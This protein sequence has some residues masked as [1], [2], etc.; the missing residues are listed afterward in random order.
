MGNRQS[1]ASS[2]KLVN[3]VRDANVIE[4]AH[5]DALSILNEDPLLEQ[6][7]H[8]ALAREA[9]LAHGLAASKQK[10]R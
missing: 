5:A 8:R 7:E 10:G 1:G 3:V 9:R 2:L 6:P 4:A